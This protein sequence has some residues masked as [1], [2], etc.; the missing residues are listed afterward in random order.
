MIRRDAL[1]LMG[2]AAAVTALGLPAFAKMN[3]ASPLPGVQPR[4]PLDEFVQDPKKVAAL[5]FAVQE[6]K[7][8]KPSDPLSWFYQ[9]A[10][11]GVSPDTLKQ[12]QKF[13]SNVTP[14]LAA[15]M[16]NK[17]PHNGENSANFLP[18][19]RGYTYHFERI[20]RLHTGIADFS[21]PYWNYL[22]VTSED[23]RTFPKE[24]GVMHL[25]GNQQNNDPANINPLYLYERDYYFC[26]YEHPFATGLPL[27]ILSRGAVDTTQVMACPVFFGLTENEG[28]GGGIADTDTTTRG[29]VEKYPHDQIHRSVGGIVKSPDM[30]DGSDSVGAMATPPTAA[31]DPIFSVHH[32]TIDWIWVQW[33]LMPGKSWGTIPNQAWFN[34][35]PW[36]FI[37][38]DGSIVN[39]PRKSYFDHRALGI[40]YKYEDLT[41]QP[42]KLPALN[43]AFAPEHF[44]ARQVKE[45]LLI[46]HEFELNVGKT[47]LASAALPANVIAQLRN[48]QS[49]ISKDGKSRIFLRLKDVQLGN[50]D[51]TGY[52]LYLVAPG[53][54]ELT[55]DASSFIGSVNLFEHH[56]TMQGMAG[57]KEGNN[58]EVFDVSKAISQ[59]AIPEHL[60]L[61]VKPFAL[62][63]GPRKSVINTP[64]KIRGL[65]FVVQA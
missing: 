57:M 17:C 4:M 40:S 35:K 34:E 31:F 12:A 33:S 2:T 46:K 38:T 41:K 25:D 22:D 55:R 43:N 8:R 15:K 28:I 37:D 16:W 63:E 1:K 45:H 50:I 9:A 18:W 64:L 59:G 62:Y 26:N 61:V 47:N 42:L 7:K 39:E 5:R 21:L 27:T 30:P 48:N 14:N 23:K 3:L 51:G 58:P 24:Y 10:I 13:D 44:L 6:M 56:H 19:H 65:E 32:T 54:K 11:H 53:H 52:E 20:V 49:K 36:H 29:L 60:T